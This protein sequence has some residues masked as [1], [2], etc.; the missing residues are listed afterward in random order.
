MPLHF[1]TGISTDKIAAKFEILSVYSN[2]KGSQSYQC[3]PITGK[4]DCLE[5]KYYLLSRSGANSKK[6]LGLRSAEHTPTRRSALQS[7][8]ERNEH[9]I[10]TQF[11]VKIW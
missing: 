5:G 10:I 4:C 8:L 2:P 6:N 11:L 9:F 3:N 1:G 7:I